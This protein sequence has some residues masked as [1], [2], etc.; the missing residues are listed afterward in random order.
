MIEDLERILAG[1]YSPINLKQA[2]LPVAAVR[3][4]IFRN[5]QSSPEV[6]TP[7][8][9]SA[10][11]FVKISPGQPWGLMDVAARS[12]IMPIMKYFL[13]RTSLRPDSW[14][15]SLPLQQGSPR[16]VAEQQLIIIPGFS[17]FARFTSCRPPGG[18]SPPQST[19]V[20]A[21]AG[22]NALGDHGHRASVLQPPGGLS[23]CAESAYVESLIR[24][25]P[26]S[27]TSATGRSAISSI[28]TSSAITADARDARGTSSSTNWRLAARVRRNPAESLPR[29]KSW[30]RGRSRY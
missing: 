10:R 7:P 8:H 30:S 6:Y 9:F 26:C 13:T 15:H 20:P 5:R 4:V 22:G 3:S 1:Q 12:T 16:R 28:S 29:R 11:S 19:R 24:M 14:V 17:D 27:M 21:C 18:S 23:G 25:A 2:P